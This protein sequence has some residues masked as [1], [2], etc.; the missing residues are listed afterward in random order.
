MTT[1]F[2]RLLESTALGEAQA[3]FLIAER[4]IRVIATAALLKICTE[5]LSH[6]PN[7]SG[8]PEL[9]IYVR[10]RLPDF[11]GSD[12]S[13]V[14]HLDFDQNQSHQLLE[15]S[16]NTALFQRQTAFLTHQQCAPF[17]Q[18]IRTWLE[19]H[20]ITLLHG[21]A[22]S[23]SD[24]A[25]LLVGRSGSGKSTT[26]LLALQAGMGFLGDDYCAVSLAPSPTVF[27]LYSS[28][29]FHLNNP[30]RPDYLSPRVNPDR[31]KGFVMLAG[32]YKA[33]LQLQAPL[34][35][36]IVPTV[37]GNLGFETISPQ[38][39]LLSLAPST[40]FQLQ[41]TTIA[42]AQMSAL[43]KALPCYRFHLGATPSQIAPALKALLEQ[44]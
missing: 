43:V 36:V 7:F 17:L 1:P 13:A 10:R 31:E 20:N 27:S 26:S 41:S 44:S 22:I 14:Q 23:H 38:A 34:K 25:A 19:Q 8:S 32:Q 18:L 40:L 9:Q 39:A 5:A 6:L 30:V 4:K 28:A 12:L 2:S 11:L 3:D 37:G 33:Q 42:F 35:A 24:G 16:S 21:A 29:K 15:S